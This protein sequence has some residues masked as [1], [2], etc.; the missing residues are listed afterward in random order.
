MFDANE[1]RFL[2]RDPISFTV[3]DV[4]LYEYGLSGPTRWLDPSGLDSERISGTEVERAG[5]TVDLPGGAKGTVKVYKNVTLKNPVY[6]SSAG[7]IQLEFTSTAP[8]EKCHWLQ[9]VYRYRK[10]KEGKEVPGTYATGDAFHYYGVRGRHVDSSHPTDPFYDKNGEKRREEKEISI[11]DRPNIDTLKG[12]TETGA[13]YDAY[14]ICD[15]RVYYHVHWEAINR[16]DASREW[17]RTYENVSGE[18][19]D[20]LPPWA[21]GDELPGGYRSRDRAKDELSRPSVYQNPIPAE[22]RK[23]WKD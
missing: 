16:P 15:G 13:V 9:F 17:S 21:R 12:G 22:V 11:F 4:N 18:K 3:G 20:K 7:W 8:C 2:Q 14:L 1:G 10:D 5:G 23:T 19:T 6:E